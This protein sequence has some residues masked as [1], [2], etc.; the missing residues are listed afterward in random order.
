MAFCPP[1]LPPQARSVTSKPAKTLPISI[2]RSRGV[3][4]SDLLRGAGTKTYAS[5]M[6]QQSSYD[7]LDRRLQSYKYPESPYDFETAAM[8]KNEDQTVTPRKMFEI[9]VEVRIAHP[10]SEHTN[11]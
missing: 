4:I 8:P 9:L 3:G 11:A 6:R 7:D 1:I 2:V 5:T 10:V